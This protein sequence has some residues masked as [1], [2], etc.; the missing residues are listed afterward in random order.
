MLITNLSQPSKS[1]VHDEVVDKTN[2]ASNPHCNFPGVDEEDSS[3]KEEYRDDNFKA[4]IPQIDHHIHD[5]EMPKPS[6]KS[7]KGISQELIV[8]FLSSDEFPDLLD[9]SSDFLHKKPERR[10]HH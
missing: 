5:T 8:D 7:H 1:F 9:Y 2:D 3:W 4:G 10:E 6:Q